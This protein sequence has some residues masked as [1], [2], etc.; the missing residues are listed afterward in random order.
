VI[1]LDEMGGAGAEGC[2]LGAWRDGIGWDGS[3]W[4]RLS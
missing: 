3:R 4:V 1:R 2:V